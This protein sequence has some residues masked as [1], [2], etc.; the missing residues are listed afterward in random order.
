MLYERWQQVMA[1]NRGEIALAD[2]ASGVS[3][4]FEQLEREAAQPPVACQWL[5]Y[6]SAVPHVFV[7]ELLRR[8]RAGQC[9]CAVEAEQS[10][11][12]IEH[13]PPL[14]AHLKVTSASTGKSRCVAF[15]AEQLAADAANIVSTMGLRRD[16]PNVGVISLAHSYG[17]S[18]LVLPLLLQGIPLHFARAFPQSILEVSKGLRS[19]TLA[20]VPALWRAWFDAGSIPA[21]VALA[22]SAGAPLP[23]PLEADVFQRSGLKIHNFYGATEC[24]GI[25][26]DGSDK[27]RTD[28]SLVGSALH[29]VN[30]SCSTDGCLIVRGPAVGST[31]WP[32]PEPSLADGA[33]L[34]SD[35]VELQGDAVFLQGRASDQINVAGRKVAPETIEQAI[36]AH[37][38]V[39]Q[40]VVFGVPSDQAERTE[41]I[42]A[43]LSLRPGATVKLLREAVKLPSWQMPREWLVVKELPVNQRGKLSRS[44]LRNRFLRDGHLGLLAAKS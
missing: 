37:P 10:P 31:Y 39:R 15:T 43:C 1:E 28:G 34:A 32:E 14:W 13:F 33:F 36:L 23:L 44:E 24:G 17:F 27:P 18:N 20:A 7:V 8:W 6:D 22:I 16:W 35:V 11:P 42:V 38:D 21:N 12:D 26:Y 25:A 19:V 3:F 9:V 29:N 40:C 30:L 4:T 41:S 5:F 2:S